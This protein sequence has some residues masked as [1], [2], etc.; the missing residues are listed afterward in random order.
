MKK[1]AY[2]APRIRVLPLDA[3]PTM[4]TASTSQDDLDHAEAKPGLWDEDEDDDT[5]PDRSWDFRTYHY[6]VWDE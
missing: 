3:A 5:Q 1:T 2:T 6:S 4:F